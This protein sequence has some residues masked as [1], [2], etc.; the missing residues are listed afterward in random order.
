ML[1]ILNNGWTRPSLKI[2]L[3]ARHL[4]RELDIKCLKVDQ[5]TREPKPDQ[6]VRPLALGLRLS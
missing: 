4:G 2:L 5:Q 3:K 6:K 1:L